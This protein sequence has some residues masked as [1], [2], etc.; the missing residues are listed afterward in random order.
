[1]N[2]WPPV[3]FAK[4]L[5]ERVTHRDRRGVGVEGSTGLGF[6]VEGLGFVAAYNPKA[7]NPKSQPYEA[8]LNPPTRAQDL[9][10]VGV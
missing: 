2:R 9:I 10:W 3:F 6:R 5:Y 7:Q 4:G 8:R 1:M